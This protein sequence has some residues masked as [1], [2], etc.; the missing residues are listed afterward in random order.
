MLKVVTA[1]ADDVIIGMTTTIA[2]SASNRINLSAEG[3]LDWFQLSRGSVASN[4]TAAHA[5]YVM[6]NHARKLNGR[7]I[8]PVTRDHPYAGDRIITNDAP[9]FYSV[10]PGD[11]DPDRLGITDQ[12]GL[13]TRG[14]GNALQFTLEPDDSPRML[15]VYHG[16]YSGTFTIELL[17]NGSAIYSNLGSAGNNAHVAY[18]TTLY[19]EPF[20]SSDVL[21][22]RVTLNSVTNSNGSSNICAATLDVPPTSHTLD[23]TSLVIKVGETGRITAFPPSSVTWSSSDTSVAE[24][25]QNG[26]VKGLKIGDAM[27]TAAL[28]GD[29]KQCMVTV[30]SEKAEIVAGGY[31]ID[32]SDLPKVHFA[33]HPEWVEVYEAT[34]NMHKNNIKKIPAAL[35]PEMD[36]MNGSPGPYFVDEAF[37]DKIF[38]WDT[39]FMMMFDKWGQHQFP[40]LPSIDNFYY[41]QT[42]NPGGENDGYICKE[43]EESGGFARWI[44]LPAYRDPCAINPPIFSWAEWEQYLIHGDP[45]RFLK[46]IEGKSGDNIMTYNPLPSGTELTIYERLVKFYDFVER[47]QRMDFS[48]E[49]AKVAASGSPLYGRTNGYGNGLDNTYNQ[50]PPFN[51]SDVNSAGDQSFNDLSIQHAQDAYFLKKI[52]EVLLEADQANKAK[53]EADI[54]RFDAEHKRITKL[55]NDLMWDENEKMFSNLTTRINQYPFATLVNDPENH[56]KGIAH[57]RTNVSSPTTLW[58]LAAHVATQQQAED[59]V[60]YHG[61][62]SNR[63]F[64]PFGLGTADYTDTR[65]VQGT[66]LLYYPEGAYWRGS[67]WAPTSFQY[68]KGLS[69]Y[70]FDNLAFEE[71][72]RH[73]E[74]ANTV[75]KATGTVWENYS[76][77]YELRGSSSRSNFAGWTGCMTIGNIMDEMLGLRMDAPNNSIG[78]NIR[79]VEE[80]GVSDLWFKH[81]GVAN[82][83]SLLA[84]ARTSANDPVTFTVTAEHA[85]TLRV[86]NNNGLEQAIDVPAGTSTYTASGKAGNAPMLAIHPELYSEAE[87]SAETLS[88]AVDYVTFGAG[89]NAS[90]IDGIKNQIRKDTG[91]INNV[92]TIGETWARSGYAL[93]NRANAQMTELGIIGAREVTRGTGS[94]GTVGGTRGRQGF[95]FEIAAGNK[96]RTATVIVGVTGGNAEIRAELMDASVPRVSAT[97]TGGASET[98]YAVEIPFLAASDGHNMI[99]KILHDSTTGDAVI[100][101]KGIILNEGF[102]QHPI[103]ISYRNGVTTASVRCVNNSEDSGIGA[104]LLLAQY[105]EAGKLVHLSISDVTTIPSLGY[106]TLNL[107]APRAQGATNAKAFL[108]EADTLVPLIQSASCLLQ[109]PPKML[110][111]LALNKPVRASSQQSDN[112]AP[113]AV[114]GSRTSGRWC[115]SSGSIPQWIEVDLGESYDLEKIDIFWEM[116]NRYYQYVIWGRETEIAN[117]G[118]NPGVNRNLVNEGYTRLADRSTNTTN[119]NTSDNV[120][121]AARY[122]VI[123]ITGVS[124]TSVWASLFSLEVVGWE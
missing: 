110:V 48:P 5:D 108:W 37:N 56:L 7:G 59:L 103:T 119:G 34:W 114:N 11:A 124:S 95:M 85:F 62:N 107:N 75:Y 29:S 52:A 50:A 99:V 20:T 41:N 35:N 42:D 86:R 17:K 63:L 102:V 31:P 15:K 43:F 32:M 3:T 22:V 33:D 38:V 112:P 96:P 117:W 67:Y 18:R 65:T 115:A 87:L 81:N 93:N 64:R 26:N 69:E 111:N 19:I 97:L 58:A 53:Y 12:Y 83:V 90:V 79:L 70:G 21:L 6:A 100:A 105:D 36:Q 54:A 77:D 73:L 39:M 16:G 66:R 80:H 120:S 76:S 4:W 84:E 98:I 44:V 1:G 88:A 61:H 94:S 60:K 113:S 118:S 23:K 24:V 2:S 14:I 28:N 57:Y 27:I 123:Q 46:K 122:I 47:Y 82:R 101:L 68:I 106:A 8:G 9:F 55:I 74:S 10:D 121:G 51:G 45:T 72:L 109:E 25:D 40:T 30:V 71:A 91:L 13:I 92:N 78:W 104:K 89:D 49:N 116:T